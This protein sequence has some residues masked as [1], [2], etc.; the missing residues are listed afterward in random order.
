MLKICYSFFTKA[1][2]IGAIGKPKRRNG[3]FGVLT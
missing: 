3:V 2:V 1:V